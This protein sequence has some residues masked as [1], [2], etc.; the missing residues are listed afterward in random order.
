M[1]G[2]QRQPTSA[3]LSASSADLPAS[4]GVPNV[5]RTPLHWFS[6]SPLAM[7]SP[8]P[9]RLLEIYLADHLAAS[10]AGVALARRT[11]ESNAGTALG[12]VLRRLTREI[13][14]DRRTLQRIVAELGFRE[15]KAKNTVAWVGERVGRLKLNGQLRGYSPLSRML[16]LEALSVGVAGKLALWQSLQSVP[17]LGERFPDCDLDRLAERARRQRAEIDDQ[18][19]EAARETFGSS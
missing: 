1:P 10:T 15:S 17:A 12:D 18:R 11:A 7:R 16:E 2:G 14:D 8:T 13:E 9:D 19:I 5:H 4:A 3:E 6:F